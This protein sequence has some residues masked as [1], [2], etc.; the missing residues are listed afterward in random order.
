MTR[1]KVAGQKHDAGIRNA[2]HFYALGA[3]CE[4]RRLEIELKT[5]GLSPTTLK[6]VLPIINRRLLQASTEDVEVKA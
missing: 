3:V 5:A 6:E 1:P 2:S 4:L